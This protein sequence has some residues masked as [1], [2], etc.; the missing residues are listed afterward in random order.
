MKCF[1]IILQLMIIGL[2]QLSYCL[3]QFYTSKKEH[4]SDYE[5]VALPKVITQ[6]DKDSEYVTQVKQRTTFNNDPDN[7]EQHST[8]DVEYEG[9]FNKD[10]YDS[11][12]NNNDNNDYSDTDKKSQDYVES[13]YI[14]EDITRYEKEIRKQKGI[15]QQFKHVPK[16]SIT[17]Y[18]EFDHSRAFNKKD[19]PYDNAFTSKDYSNTNLSELFEKYSQATDQNGNVDFDLNNYDVDI[20]KLFAEQSKATTNENKY[21]NDEMQNKYRQ[22][23]ARY[24]NDVISAK[25]RNTDKGNKWKKLDNKENDKRYANNYDRNFYQGHM[26]V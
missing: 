18:N 2:C 6:I 20:D 21:Y 15:S 13:G 14:D 23:N 1:L 8:D 5:I 9:D 19:G 26:N 4:N 11:N 7:T 17:E 24:D 25:H 10:S 16:N 22:K 12:I 3:S